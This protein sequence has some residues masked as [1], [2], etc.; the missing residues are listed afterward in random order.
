LDVIDEVAEQTNL[1]ALN[2]SIIAAQA[3]EH[4]RGFAVVADEIKDLATRVSESTKEISKIVKTVQ[5]DSARAAVAMV[6]GNTQVKEGLKLAR[7][8]GDALEKIILGAQWSANV[9]TDIADA[10]QEQTAMNQTIEE[11]IQDVIN[12]ATEN[13]RA[14]K[15]QEIGA[16]RV[17][18]A[19]AKMTALADQVHRATIEQTKGSAEVINATEEISTLV[20]NSVKN[21]Q[22]LI[23]NAKELTRY[24]EMLTEL[25][26]QYQK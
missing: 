17:M 14:T 20:R 7:L 10:I 13:T 6:E 23:D 22:Q 12:V 21:I 3:G 26:S 2:A 19:V 11:S 5:E 1:L 8:A 16:S 4:G 9:A 18:E 25:L 24:A 15:E